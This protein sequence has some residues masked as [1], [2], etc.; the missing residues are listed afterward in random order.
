VTT[1]LTTPLRFVPSHLPV[2]LA[3]GYMQR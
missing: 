2:V 1:R 3:L